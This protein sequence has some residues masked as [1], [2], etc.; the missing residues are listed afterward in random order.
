MKLSNN[1]YISELMNR[2][3]TSFYIGIEKMGSKIIHGINDYVLSG[4]KMFLP[5]HLGGGRFFYHA[6]AFFEVENGSKGILIEYGGKPKGENYLP[7][8]SSSSSIYP[9][10]YKYGKQGGLRYQMISYFDFNERSDE[11]IECIIRRYYKPTVN[12]LLNK[13]CDNSNWR[14][15]DYNLAF[16]NCQD[17]VCKFIDILDAVRPKYEY[18]RGFHNMAISHYP[19]CIIKQLEKNEDDVSQIPDKIPIVGPI[20]ECFRLLGYGIYSLFKG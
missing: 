16:H 20:Q 6:T 5:A 2:K 3:I 19:C 4:Y 12:E 8:S 10:I 9:L 15:N 18:F 7:G 14:R 1:G 11:I 13:I 17:F